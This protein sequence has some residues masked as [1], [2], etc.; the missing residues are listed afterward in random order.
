MAYGSALRQLG[1]GALSPSLRREELRY[2]GTWERVEYPLA[3]ASMMLFFV[4]FAIWFIQGQQHQK[5][6]Q[7]VRWWTMSLNKHLI[8][9]ARPGHLY[10]SHEDTKFVE[11]FK[12]SH[13]KPEDFDLSADLL[14]K[15][16]VIDRELGKAVDNLKEFAGDGGL[17]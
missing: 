14:A 2:T 4:L 6:N 16:R 13:S 10:P 15:L 3:V 1:G 12:D 7:N 8:G 17:G 11:E 5:L 9:D